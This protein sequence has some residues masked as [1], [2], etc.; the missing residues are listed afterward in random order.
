MVATTTELFISHTAPSNPA[1][2]KQ[3]KLSTPSEQV[4]PFLHGREMHR[5]GK[6]TYFRQMSRHHSEAEHGLGLH[7][8]LVVQPSVTPEY[9]ID[10]TYWLGLDFAKRA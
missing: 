3:L 10:I 1:G 5:R 4:P 6:Q 8:G 9:K 7:T 2:H